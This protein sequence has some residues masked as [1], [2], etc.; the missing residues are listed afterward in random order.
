MLCTQWGMFNSKKQDCREKKPSESER[1]IR[2]EYVCMSNAE[3][4][5]AYKTHSNHIYTYMKTV[6]YHENAIYRRQT[7]EIRAHITPPSNKMYA[8]NIT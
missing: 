8:P 5:C 4:E 3:F 1:K 2:P 6:D 7:D